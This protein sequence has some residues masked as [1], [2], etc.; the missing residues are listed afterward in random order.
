MLIPSEELRHLNEGPRVD[1]L[2]GGL[3]LFEVQVL[4]PRLAAEVIARAKA[5]LRAVVSMSPDELRQGWGP[6]L[7]RWFTEACSPEQTEGAVE[8]WLSWWR[9]LDPEAR[10]LA[11]SER[12]WTL[13]DWTHWMHP[14]ERQWFWWDA[15]VGDCDSAV[16]SVEIPGWPPAVGALVWLLRV[17]GADEVDAV[18][19]E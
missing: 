17:A 18:E 8:A 9:D 10:A 19:M 11:A 5:V 13:A 12:P 6:R 4:A 14:E 3:G 2:P 15:R 7:P 1:E 16:V